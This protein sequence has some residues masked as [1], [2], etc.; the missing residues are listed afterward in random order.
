MEI[1]EL[2]EALGYETKEG[3]DKLSNLKEKEDESIWV[4]EI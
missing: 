3:Y 1:N 2:R 4:K